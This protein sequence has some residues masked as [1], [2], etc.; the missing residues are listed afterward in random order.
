MATSL[1]APQTRPSCSIERTAASK[2][3][4][5]VSSSQGFTS[6]VT[7]DYMKPMRFRRAVQDS[8]TYF[9]DGLGFVGLLGGIC[10]DTLRLDSLSFCIFILIISEEINFLFLLLSGSNLSCSGPKEGLSGSA[11]SRKRSMLCGVGFDVIVPPR[12]VRVRI[13]GSR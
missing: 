11:G 12:Y 3:A 7:T 13:T 4:M 9:G 6:K 2:A 10:S 1:P 5:S 8:M